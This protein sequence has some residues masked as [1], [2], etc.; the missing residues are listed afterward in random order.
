MVVP[1]FA[2]QL[3]LTTITNWFDLKTHHPSQE[4]ST[5]DMICLSRKLQTAR[6]AMQRLC[7][8]GRYRPVDLEVLGDRIAQ[9][10]AML[11]MQS[12]DV[13]LPFE[14][15]LMGSEIFT[16]YNAALG[17]RLL[18]WFGEPGSSTGGSIFI[19]GSGFSV[20]DMKVIV[21]GVQVSD[22]GAAGAAAP[23]FDMV[24]RNVLRVEH[25][26]H[27]HSDPDARRFQGSV[28][29]MLQSGEWEG[30]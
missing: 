25:P 20:R 29:P 21:G 10:E 23:S 3:K 30:R 24:S 5:T 15:D 26:A 9:L 27:G 28:T 4:L 1:N 2:P 14:A 22:G 12:H 7:D 8:S 13:V 11:P 17:P 6:N 16:S 18:T 19:L